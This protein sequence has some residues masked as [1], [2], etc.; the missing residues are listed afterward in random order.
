[1][2]FSQVNANSFISLNASWNKVQVDAF[3]QSMQA[4]PRATNNASSLN[5]MMQQGG[6]VPAGQRV[7]GFFGGKFFTTSS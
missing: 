6:L 4:N 2:S 1:M 5:Q 3:L 7:V